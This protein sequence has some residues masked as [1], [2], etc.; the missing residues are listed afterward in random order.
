VPSPIAASA[1][2]ESGAR[3]PEQPSEQH[4]RANHLTLDLG[5]GSRGVRADQAALQLRPILGPDVFGRK[6]AE[7]GGHA[8]VG[9]DVVGQCLDDLARRD[10]LGP[11]LVREPHRG[12]APGDCDDLV[13]GERSDPQYDL[14]HVSMPPQNAV[15]RQIPSHG[16]VWDPRHS[17]RV[18]RLS[19]QRCRP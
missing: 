13:S 6:G 8:V 5:S 12:I 4:Q 11:R 2:C 16:A 19:Q 3:S 18:W 10:D 7:A 15:L 9:L 14:V 1:Q 17:L